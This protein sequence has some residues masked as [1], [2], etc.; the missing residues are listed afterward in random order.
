MEDKMRILN[1][2]S[3]GKISA[4]EASKLLEAL[5]ADEKKEEIIAFKGKQG[6]KPTKL[7]VEV[8]ANENSKKSKVNINIPLSLVRTMGPII[9]KNLP[10]EA[11]DE[12]SGKGVDI[13]A[14]MNSIEEFI[15]AAGEEDIVNVD[16]SGDEVSKVRIYAE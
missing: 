6:R 11:R 14:I 9:A 12:M 1:L 3:E 2:L 15:E 5:G 4:E 10:Q 7:R 16:I 13:V 8:D